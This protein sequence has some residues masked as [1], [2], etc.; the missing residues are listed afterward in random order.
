MPPIIFVTAHAGFALKAF[1]LH[2]L[3]YLLKPVRLERLQA[4][5]EHARALQG[6]IRGRQKALELLAP[7]QQSSKVIT[8]ARGELRIFDA[9]RISRFS[10]LDKYVSFEEDGQQQLIEESLNQLEVRLAPFGFLRVHRAELVNLNRLRA[11][12]SQDGI[13]EVELEDGQ[14]ARVSRRFLADVKRALGR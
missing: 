4:A 9:K 2:A 13:H 3:D 7:A 5:V 11:L 6:A 14:V 12:R 1:E 10:A 8:R